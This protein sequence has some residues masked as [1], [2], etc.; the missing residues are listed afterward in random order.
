MKKIKILLIIL[1]LIFITGCKIKIKYPPVYTQ[2]QS[3]LEAKNYDNVLNLLNTK[4]QRRYKTDWYYY[5]YAISLYY[6]RPV[7]QIRYAIDDMKIALKFNSSDYYINY[8]LGRMYYDVYDFDNAKL[9]FSEALK[10]EMNN[11]QPPDDISAAL[12]MRILSD[13]TTQIL[14][15]TNNLV[16]SLF[17]KCTEISDKSNFYL[18]LK[19]ILESDCSEYAKLFLMKVCF[20]RIDKTDGEYLK[21]LYFDTDQTEL[22]KFLFVKILYSYLINREIELF[23]MELIENHIYDNQTGALFFESKYVDVVTEFYKYMSFYYYII[24]N[25]VAANT[26]FHM[27]YR[28]KYKPTEYS[29]NITD[30]LSKLILEFKNDKQ[31][32][33]IKVLNNK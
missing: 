33:E 4:I 1:N 31:F 13:E 30:D 20:T 6:T 7:S 14:D 16:S 5:A 8:Y 15:S 29:Y 17:L 18:T 32:N 10:L 25:N 24:D 27:Y 9:Y 12:W 26:L 2:V 21:K 23:K 28:T 11:T 22:K 3:E 19:D